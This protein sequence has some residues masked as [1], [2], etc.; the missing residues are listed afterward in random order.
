MGLVGIP[1]F[2]LGGGLFYIFKPTFGYLLAFTVAS[3]IAGTVKRGLIKRIIVNA[4]A[5]IVIHLIGVSYF[6]LISN[7]YLET[8]I[9]VWESI[10]TGSLFF[11]PIDII[12]AVISAILSYKLYNVVHR[13]ERQKEKV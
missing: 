3:V 2:A 4:C 10:L 9:S 1:V 5:V 7:Y 11:L 6:Y 13:N 12:S 8:P